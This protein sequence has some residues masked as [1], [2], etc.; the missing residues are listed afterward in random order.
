MVGIFLL[1]HAE[2][3]NRGRLNLLEVVEMIIEERLNPIDLLG[4]HLEAILLTIVP[5]T[6]F[7]EDL[8]LTEILAEDIQTGVFDFECVDPRRVA[9]ERWHVWTPRGCS[10]GSRLI[11]LARRLSLQTQISLL[12]TI[13]P[14]QLLPMLCW[15]YM[16]VTTLTSAIPIVI[17]GD[18]GVLP[19]LRSVNTGAPNV[20]AYA[21][22]RIG[23]Q[24]DRPG[25]PDVFER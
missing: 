2:R 25:F 11:P 1:H 19:V 14:A 17:E 18:A 15:A 10:G 5:F 8:V 23:A 6:E 21:N 20:G 16:W 12:P 9:I 4:R 3:L 22:Q 24:T 7:V 13:T